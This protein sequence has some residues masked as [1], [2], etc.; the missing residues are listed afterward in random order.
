[1][2]TGA[3][4]GS[5]STAN[6]GSSGYTWVVPSNG[7]SYLFRY[8]CCNGFNLQGQSGVISVLSPTRAPTPYPTTITTP[9]PTSAPVSSQG[10][11][12]NTERVIKITYFVVL[13]NVFWLFY[14]DNAGGLPDRPVEFGEGIFVQ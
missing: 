2:T 13:S 12:F 10:K 6:K 7:V 1:M 4:S 11:K 8:Y 14:H 9:S 5:F 3:K